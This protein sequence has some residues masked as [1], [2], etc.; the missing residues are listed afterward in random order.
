MPWQQAVAEACIAAE[1]S[2]KITV[3][4][5]RVGECG[6]TGLIPSP[7]I[8]SRNVWEALCAVL[9]VCTTCGHY[10]DTNNGLRARC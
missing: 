3:G 6:S 9:G 5:Q 10:L 1:E 7:F 8:H 4:K 2:S